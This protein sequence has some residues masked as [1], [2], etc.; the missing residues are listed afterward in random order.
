MKRGLRGPDEPQFWPTVSIIPLR[1]CVD[2]CSAP[3]G[4]IHPCLPALP[5]TY[6]EVSW[7][8]AETPENS[9]QNLCS[10][11]GM[12]LTSSSFHPAHLTRIPPPKTK[13]K[14]RTTEQIDRAYK[15]SSGRADPQILLFNLYLRLHLEGWPTFQIRTR[16]I[17]LLSQR[18]CWKL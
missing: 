11:A 7:I 15:L 1:P 16:I 14:K 5:G 4:E 18:P 8:T 13:Q 3:S 2:R 9:G 17:C 6:K 12:S 10:P